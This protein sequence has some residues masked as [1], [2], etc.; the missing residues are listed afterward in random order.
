MLLPK[1]AN[2]SAEIDLEWLLKVM[3][4][5]EA[6]LYRVLIRMLS[7]P[8]A[9]SPIG[10]SRG[11]QIAELA[12][13]TGL[14]KRWVIELLPRLEEKN[15]VR[16]EGGSGT[17]KW[18]RLLTPG[19]PLLGGPKADQPAQKGVAGPAPSPGK[20]K[21]SRVAALQPKRR[22][23]ETAPGPKPGVDFYVAPPVEKPAETPAR[24]R[25]VPTPSIPPADPA[26]DNPA[27]PASVVTAAPAKRASRRRST[28]KLPAGRSHW[29]SARIKELAAYACS[30]PISL[31]DLKVPGM[32]EHLL[33]LAL[34]R[35]CQ[36]MEHYGSIPCENRWELI[37]A[38]RTILSDF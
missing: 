2:I 10:A 33:L 28:K 38:L 13:N 32:T 29:E 31:R 26:P 21:A 19:V 35:R 3:P 18:I 22:R 20:T 12:N 15:L 24:R 30:Q 27:A 36:R 11:I 1:P 6:K 37:S 23:K 8:N 17:V 9:G 34:E 5:G 4:A 16:T 25:K 7:V 14:S